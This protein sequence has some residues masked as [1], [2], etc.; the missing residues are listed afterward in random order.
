MAERCVRGIAR[1]RGFS[2]S[3]AE[4]KRRSNSSHAPSLR[5]AA[6]RPLQRSTPESAR[7]QPKGCG[8]RSFRFLGHGHG[9][10]AK[11]T[12]REPGRAAL[13]RSRSSIDAASQQRRP[14]IDGFMGRVHGAVAKPASHELTIGR[15]CP[16]RAGLDVLHS[17]RA[18]RR[19]GLALPGSWAMSRSDRHRELSM[20]RRFVAA[21][22]TRR[23]LWLTRKSASSRRRLRFMGRTCESAG[24]ALAANPG[25]VID[26]PSS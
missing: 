3:A 13:P 25:F 17:R 18:A 6:F 2:F 19:D 11:E 23:T 8:P 15:A 9:F 16:Q 12:S 10:L 21:E 26:S 5:T 4:S 22:V 1:N 20:N 14:T 7:K 24:K